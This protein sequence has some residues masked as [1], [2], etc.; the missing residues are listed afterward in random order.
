[1]VTKAEVL[2]VLREC[3][4]PEIPINI[5]DLGLIQGIEIRGG[6]VKIK[7]G[8]TSPYC[9]MASLIVGDVEEK[10]KK[11]KGIKKVNVELLPKFKWPPKRLSEE[12]RK[13]LGL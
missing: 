13:K 2:K 8:L 11:I 5:V 10:V 7:M 1:M 9:P 3:Y 6:N 12:A 4:D